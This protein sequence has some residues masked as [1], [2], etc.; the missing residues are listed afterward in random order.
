MK[1]MV[2]SLAVRD[3]QG[4]LGGIIDVRRGRHPGTGA[5]AILALY[6]DAK[7]KGRIPAVHM[8]FPVVAIK[9]GKLPSKIAGTGGRGCCG[10]R[11]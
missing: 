5:H 6:S 3:L 8:N 1:Q 9:V 10:G 4:R 2:L 11:K 7:D